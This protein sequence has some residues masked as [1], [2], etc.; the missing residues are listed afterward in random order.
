MRIKPALLFCLFF[1]LHTVSRA[2]PVAPVNAVPTI[3]KG[4]EP[5]AAIATLATLKIRDIEKIAGRK[6]TW[7]E[8][9]VIKVYQ[10]KLKKEL[11]NKKAGDRKSSPGSTAM[12]FGIIGLV[13]LFIPIPVIGGLASIICIILALVLGYQARKK[14]PADKKAKTAI[15]LGWIGVGVIVLA[16]VLLIALL[17]ALSL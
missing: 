5:P 9:V 1:S 6:L 3:T 2:L 8:K 16:I 13:S 4:I 10:W 17:S 12:T 11:R 15:I 7:K 14:D